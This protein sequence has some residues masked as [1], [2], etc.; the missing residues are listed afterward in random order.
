MN[1][2]LII[3]SLL[4][5]L[6]FLLL[7]RKL[8]N[9]FQYLLSFIHRMIEQGVNIQF[10]T[11]KSKC[12]LLNTMCTAYGM[13]CLSHFG[14]S[15]YFVQYLVLF[16]S[17]IF[18]F[19]C[20]FSLSW[21]LSLSDIIHVLP[22]FLRRKCTTFSIFKIIIVPYIQIIIITIYTYNMRDKRRAPNTYVL[23]FNIYIYID[24]I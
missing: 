13:Q 15:L 7:I 6:D 8:P 23:V 17:F 24:A 19:R 21:A 22:F 5:L 16:L 9:V 20:I 3:F 11:D 1:I 10:S 2:S 14:Q 4:V 18:R 12:L